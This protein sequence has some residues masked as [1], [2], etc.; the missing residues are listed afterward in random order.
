MLRLEDSFLAS[1]SSIPAE[2]GEGR[3][4]FLYGGG[5]GGGGQEGRRSGG[6]A[7]AVV[8][9]GRRDAKG[10]RAG[11][12]ADGSN[13]KVVA[14]REDYEDERNF[15]PLQSSPSRYPALVDV[16]QRS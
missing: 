15:H 13:L 8:V 2:G 6:G 12:G 1:A 9:L 7:G 16:K 10:V 5:R 4:S 3:T 14:G 11:G